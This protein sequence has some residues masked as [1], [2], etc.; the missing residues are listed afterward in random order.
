MTVFESVHHPGDAPAA[1]VYGRALATPLGFCTL[2]VMI[3]TAAA[4]LQQQPIWPFLAWGLPLALGV[5][6]AWT[7]FRLGSTP[8]EVRI[9]DHQA[10]VRSVH[11]CVHGHRQGTPALHWQWIHDIRNGP[12][13]LIVT[14]G[15]E[16]HRFLYA[17]WPNHRALLGALQSARAGPA[18]HA[19]S[20]PPSP[21]PHA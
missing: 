9:R 18:A 2:P 15:F 6:A 21:A 20:A 10:A 4:A 11:D 5:A 19:P 13:A 3:A 14:M 12:D 7:R 16:T 17:A 1:L 8:A